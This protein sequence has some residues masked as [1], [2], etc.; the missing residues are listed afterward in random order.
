M[1]DTGKLKGILAQFPYSFKFSP[2]GLNYIAECDDLFK[3]NS[4]FVEFR[5]N[6][7]VNR[8]MYDNLKSAGIG[9]VAVDEPDLRG[10]LKPDLFN[11]T[12]TAY[13]RLHG[14]NAEQW[15]N[16]GPLRYDYDYSES[17]L[18]EWKEKID[19]M[20]DKAHKMYIFFNNC[21]LGQA[22]KNAREMIQ[23]LNL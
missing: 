20:K 18:R 5:H 1:E 21:H 10:L 9:Y 2:D 14:R 8:K 16:G 15:W 3:P 6:G 19:K 23:M 12:D 22:V 7:W 11:T 13:I 17:E 4:L